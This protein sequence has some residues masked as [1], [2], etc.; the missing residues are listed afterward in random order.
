MLSASSYEPGFRGLALPLNP[1]QNFSMCS[2]ERVGWLGFR[3]L[4]KRAGNFAI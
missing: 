3:D 1:L 4:G 2:H